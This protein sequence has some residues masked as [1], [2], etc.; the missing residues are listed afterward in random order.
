VEWSATPGKAGYCEIEAAPKEIDRTDLADITGPK[1]TKNAIDRDDRPEEARYGVGVIRPRSP[2]VSKWN[3]IGNFVRAIVELR[4]AAKLTDQ[5]Q[6]A[7]MKLGN[8]HWAKLK[9]CSASL[10]RCANDS[11]VEKIEADFHPIAPSGIMEVVSPR[12]LTYRVA[13]QEWFTQ[14]VQ[15]S[16]YLPTT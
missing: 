10:R 12:A 1:S 2:I 6:E 5:V 16:L 4:R 9:A 11:M 15:A 8:G 7:R 3:G 14:G 13:C